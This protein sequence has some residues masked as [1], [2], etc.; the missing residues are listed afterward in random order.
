MP[1]AKISITK[2][3]SITERNLTDATFTLYEWNGTEYIQKETIQD[4]NNDGIYESNYYEWNKT[5][6]G[7]YKIVETG[8]PENHKDLNF[9]MEFTINQLKTTNYTITPDYNNI[10]YEI[11]YGKGNPDDFDRTNGIVENE[12]FKIKAS[13]DL[14]DSQNLKQIQNEATFKIYE[15]DKASTKSTQAI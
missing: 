9:S 5:T 8:I 2:H 15:W 10:E 11:T 1:Q 7:K 4:T 13:I 14:L 6:E 12:P 3:D